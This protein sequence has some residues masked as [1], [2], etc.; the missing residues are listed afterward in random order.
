MPTS[1]SPDEVDAPASPVSTPSWGPPR[2]P[3]PPHRLAKLANALG[4]ATPVPAIHALSSPA[5]SYAP[6][7]ILPNTAASS[8]FD[9]RRS[10]TPSVGSAHTYT[11]VTQTS[12]YL[13]HVIPPA[14]LPHES[15]NVYDNE[16]LP[17]PPSA[18]GYHAQFRRGILVPVYPTLQTQLAA[19]AKEYALPSTVGLVLYL[20][21]SSPAA[22]ASM[23]LGNMSDDRNE[24][25][26]P[27]LSEDIW[28]HIWVR[29]LKAERDEAPP[30]AVR[31]KGLGFGNPAAQSSPSL[32]QD[33][34]SN[35]SSLRPLLSPLRAETPQLMTPSPSTT[36]SHSAIS[37]RSD[38]DSPES[39]TSVSDGGDAGDVPLP[40]LHSHSLIPILAKVEFDIDRRKATWYDRWKRT[41]RVQHAKRAESR[42]GMQRRAASRTGDESGAEG[43]GEEEMDRKPAVALRLVDRLQAT[44][45]TPAYLRPSN[46]RLLGPD[47][48]DEDEYA[49]L[50]DSD[51]EG[52]D[53]D[54]TARYGQGSVSGDPLADVFGTDAEAWAD[55]H[56]ENAPQRRSKHL[57]NPNIVDLALDGAALSALP[58]P[59]EEGDT[60]EI[61]DDLEEVAELLKRSS[62]PQLSVAIPASPPQQPRRSSQSSSLSRK[63]VPPALNLAPSLPG[64]ANGNDLATD[65][66]N[67]RLAYLQEENTPSTGDF[68]KQPQSQDGEPS[69]GETTHKPMRR[70]PVGEKREGVFYDEL[71][72]GLESSYEFDEDDPH[73]RRKS[74][75][76]MMAKLDEIERNLAQFSPRKLA[77]EDLTA[78]TPTG[79][80][81]IASSLTPP[82][83]R[84]SV[85][86]GSTPNPS[87]KPGPPTEG[88]SWPAVPYSALSNMGNG[89]AEPEPSAADIPSPPRI[90]FNGISTELPK[91]PFQKR[92]RESVI[93]DETLARKRE[94]EEEQGALYPPLVAPQLLRQPASD[95]PVIPLS[96]DPFGRFPSDIDSVP[97]M[98]EEMPSAAAAGRRRH[99][100]NNKSSSGMSDAPSSRF[101]LDSVTSDE[102]TALNASTAPAKNAKQPS[103]MSVKSIKKLWRRTNKASVSSSSSPNLPE[104]GR[105]SPNSAP[106]TKRSSRTFSR[107]PQPSPQPDQLMQ[108]PQSAPT[109]ALKPKRKTSLHA[110]QFN[111]E[112]PYP[113]HPMPTRQPSPAMPPPLTPPLP[114]SAPP[115]STQTDK[116]PRK[117]ILKSFKSQSGSLSTHSSSSS[118][119]Q[120]PRSSSEMSQEGRRRKGSVVEL[121]SIMKRASGVSSSMTLVDIPRSPALPEHLANTQSRS[122]SRQSQLSNASGHSSSSRAPSRLMA[123]ASPPR[124]GSALGVPRTSGDSYES[125]PSFDESQFEIVS[126]KLAPSQALSYPYHGL[127]HSMSSAE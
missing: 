106:L 64:A 52:D 86:A 115:M 45:N 65:G 113:I 25:P 118:I 62:R 43:E 30:S 37:S 76:L 100:H 28:R 79:I 83:W 89:P 2:A 123:G 66:S 14:H 42:L 5:S 90:A 82:A 33:V 81:S 102:V 117:S 78:D 98:P 50:P 3:L 125:R 13:L 99:A 56:A 31:T 12:K 55:I 77:I 88:A 63:H 69:D 94:L 121:S 68:P 4:V 92:T 120:T 41:R 80:P 96:P 73:D 112:S 32:L 60:R 53:G 72:L 20:I 127:D 61:T 57:N 47:A 9:F 39:A 36:A 1:T 75:V 35:Q 84:G 124:N 10:P 19:I 93:S 101:S 107:S 8:A 85:T 21:N 38:L 49:Q 40:G 67:L 6:S 70:S 103:L 119:G 11:P 7:P 29:V 16:L 15:D 54:A 95:S 97:P 24:T 27:R 110:F 111:Q 108:H 126:P 46:G 105:T 23:R 87:P 74:Q 17:P 48:D 114:A 44:E 51:E 71:D 116:E 26:G 58:D 22:Q 122:N 104:S 34:M 91:S 18:S 59:G 109:T